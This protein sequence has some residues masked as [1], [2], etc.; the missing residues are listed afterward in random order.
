MFIEDDISPASFLASLSIM[1]AFL[2]NNFKEFTDFIRRRRHL[3][4]CSS[5]TRWLLLLGWWRTLFTLATL[6]FVA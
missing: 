5:L 1:I 2:F 4:V 6:L 3:L